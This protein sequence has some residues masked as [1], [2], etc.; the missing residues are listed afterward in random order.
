M[1]NRAAPAPRHVRAKDLGAEKRS[2][3]T[4]SDIRIP[5]RQRK[6]LQPPGGLQPAAADF[7]IVGGIVDQDLH[8]SESREDGIERCADAIGRSNVANKPGHISSAAGI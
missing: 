1:K 2:G 4:H 7:R 5:A 8:S 3:Q 6:V